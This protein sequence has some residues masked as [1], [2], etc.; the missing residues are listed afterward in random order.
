MRH[1]S[2]PPAPQAAQKHS[3]TSKATAPSQKRFA[4]RA[5]ALLF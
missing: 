2:A 5:V 3:R 4:P 1:A